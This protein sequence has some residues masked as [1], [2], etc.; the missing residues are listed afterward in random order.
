MTP[1]LR[2]AALAAAMLASACSEA[3]LPTPAT[4]CR[5]TVKAMGWR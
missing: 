3:A 2:L 1:P 5:R 4:A